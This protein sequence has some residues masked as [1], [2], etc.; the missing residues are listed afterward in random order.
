[1]D[2]S[3]TVVGRHVFLFIVVL[4]IIIRWFQASHR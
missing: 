1:M 2:W 3:T 4:S